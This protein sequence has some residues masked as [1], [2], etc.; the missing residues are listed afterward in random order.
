MLRCG[1]ELVRAAF[2]RDAHRTRGLRGR[3]EILFVGVVCLFF[4]FVFGCTAPC[5]TQKNDLHAFVTRI[6]KLRFLYGHRREDGMGG[7]LFV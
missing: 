2:E 1:L 6:R 4:L 7:G 5:S 3:F